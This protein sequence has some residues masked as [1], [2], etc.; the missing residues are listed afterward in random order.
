MKKQKKIG[1]IGAGNMGGAILDGIYR[2]FGIFVA[3]A[4]KDRALELQKKYKVELGGIKDVVGQTDI[5]ILAVKPQLFEEVLTDLKGHITKDHLVISIAAGIKTSFIQRKL[6][7]DIRVIRTMP[8]LPVQVKEGMTGVC[9]GK[10]VKRT[11]V[12]LA[13]QIFNA[14]G[15]TVVVEEKK[16]DALTAI[17]GSGP[18]YLF[19]VVE[20]LEK[21]AKSLGLKPDVAQQL[22]VQT[23]SGS[24]K[25]LQES[26]EDAKTLRKRV[27]SKGGTT[28]AALEV[29]EAV[30][31]DKIFREALKAARDRAK[32]L[33]K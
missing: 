28:Q 13:C 5:I 8:N 16:I 9:F 25:L 15:Q 7:K 18:A 12:I 31:T 33:S 23:L 1:L 2:D 30:K 26:P 11:D 4:D 3:E 29:F 20:C 14:I 17:S 32:E 24:L 27:T 19:Y 22:I 6:G 10:T 21:A